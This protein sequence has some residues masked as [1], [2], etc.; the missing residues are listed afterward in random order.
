[1]ATR[2]KGKFRYGDEQRD[3]RDELLDY[4][5]ANT[6]AIE[7]FADAACICGNK[8]FVLFLDD[9]EGAAVRVCL[10]CEIRHFI[11]DSED[12]AEDAKLEQCECPC[13]KGDFE[14]TAGVALYGESDDVKWLYLGCRCVACGLVACY[15][16]WKNEYENYRE[17]LARV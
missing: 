16:D 8:T 13:G 5:V 10:A 1:M 14:I 17:L 9:D 2:T 4:S 6:Y 3:I 15:G 11:S 7:H 12:Y